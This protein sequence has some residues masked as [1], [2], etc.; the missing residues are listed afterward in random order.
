[1]ELTTERGKGSVM[2]H[3]KVKDNLDDKQKEEK[4][5]VGQT[6]FR[7]RQVSRFKTEPGE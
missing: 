5:C 7:E 1:M 2:Q 4:V 6:S 3:L